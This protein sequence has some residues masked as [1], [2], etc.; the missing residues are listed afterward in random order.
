M[1]TELLSELMSYFGFGCRNIL[2]YLKLQIAG[3]QTI[4]FLHHLGQIFR[5]IIGDE[6]RRSYCWEEFHL[7][8][9]PMSVSISNTALTTDDCHVHIACL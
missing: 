3:Y 5:Y 8:A 2:G 1:K 6:S 7:P 4:V 9:M